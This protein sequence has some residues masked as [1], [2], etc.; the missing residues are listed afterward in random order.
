MARE[1][2]NE[3]HDWTISYCSSNLARLPHRSDLAAEGAKV[4]GMCGHPRASSGWVWSP[5]M[6]WSWFNYAISWF[7]TTVPSPRGRGAAALTLL[8]QWPWKLMFLQ[9]LQA[10]RDFYFSYC[11]KCFAFIAS[12]LHLC[13]PAPALAGALAAAGFFI[14]YSGDLLVQS[15]SFPAPEI[16]TVEAEIIKYFEK[17]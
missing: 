7:A 4:P 16:R 5:V 9:Y 8:R 12:L 15:N 2:T 1:T 14:A 6:C 17:N 3:I 10:S 13:F 11:T